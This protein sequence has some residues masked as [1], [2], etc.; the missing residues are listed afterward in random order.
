VQASE[1][2]NLF[3]HFATSAAYVHKILFIKIVQASE[4]PNSFEHFATSAAYVHKILFIK[5][6][7]ASEMQYKGHSLSPMKRG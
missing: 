6:V 1:M 5:I 7:Q 4:M 2:P 3:E